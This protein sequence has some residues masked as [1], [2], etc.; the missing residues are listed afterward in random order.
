M[1][2]ISHGRTHCE[3]AVCSMKPSLICTCLC[4][5]VALSLLVDGQGIEL[6]S[7]DKASLLSDSDQAGCKK[8]I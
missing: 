4:S 6:S 2:P 7:C 8:V 3:A 1:P 5:L